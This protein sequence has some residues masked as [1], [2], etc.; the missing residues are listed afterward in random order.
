MN[1]YQRLNL[2]TANTIIKSAN[3]LDRFGNRLYPKR[4][5]EWARITLR[6][7]KI[8]LCDRICECIARFG[9]NSMQV[10]C[11]LLTFKMIKV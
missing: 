7:I 8:N 11:M 4:F 10:Q 5:I 6:N 1:H 2:E 9:E 3:T